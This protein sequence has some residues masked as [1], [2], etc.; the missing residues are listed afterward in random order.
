MTRA[1]RWVGVALVAMVAA[2]VLAP[3]AVP[4]YDG[5]SNPD[6]PYRWV[7]PPAGATSGKQP[8]VAKAVVAIRNGVSGAQFANS[9]EQAPQISVYVPGG[10]LNVPAGASTVT[11]E[12]VPI[13]PTAPLPTDGTIVTNVYAISAT[14]G[15]RPV[16]VV[17][18][19]HS[20]PSLQMRAPSAGQPGPVF[21]H[22]T[23]TGWQRAGTLRVG[24]DIYQASAPTFGDWALVQLKQQPK[25][26]GGGGGGINVGLLAGGLAVLFIAGVILVIRIRRTAT[27]GP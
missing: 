26:H 4:I 23:A 24:N 2:W 12:A 9:A 11:V 25:A 20:A 8:T 15:G 1:I 7:Q 16:S 5:L 14:A 18:T 13:A 3:A 19:G 17:G 10:A 21:E 22:R 27:V 6:E